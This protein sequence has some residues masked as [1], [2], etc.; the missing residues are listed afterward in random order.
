MLDPRIYQTALIP[1]A[2]AVIVL[3]FSLYDQQ[4]PVGT[5]LAPD[6]FSGDNAY[7]TMNALA[8]AHPRRRPGSADDN[9]IAGL[10]AGRLRTYGFSV[11]TSA[12]RAQT[13]DG[14]R[15]LKN[16]IGVRAGP[17][18]GTIVVVAHRDALGSPA[19][20]QASGTAVLLELAQV[21]SGETQHRTI[22]LA[23]TSGSAGAAGAAQL[24]RSLPGP[25]DAVI[26]L[27]DL[28]ASGAREPIV[29]PWSNGEDLAP[30]R[31]RQTVAAAV[32]AQAGLPAGRTTLT[33]ELAHVALPMATSEQAPFAAHKE[34]ALLVSLSGERQPPAHEP[35]TLA[36]ITSMGRAVLQ[37]VTA[38]DSGPAVPA[39]SA[40]L[41]FAGK[42]IPAWA[43]RVLVLTL[44]LPVLGTAIDGLARARRRG[45][46]PLRSM[47]WVLAAA[48]PFGLAGVAIAAGRATGLI[49]A[50]PPGPVGPGAVPLRGGGIAVLA[51]C[52]FLILTGVV[53]V[54]ALG[55]RLP[56]PRGARGDEGPKASGVPPALLLALCGCSLAIWVTNPFAAAL[57][58]PALHLWLWIL[59][60]D[61]RLRGA[62]VFTLLVA[63]LAPVVLGAV[64]FALT[65]GLGPVKLAWNGVLLIAGGDVHAVSVAEWS[66]V[67][68][69]GVCVALIIGHPAR[70]PRAQQ[71]PVTIRGPVTYAGPGSLGGTESAIRR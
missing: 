35:T 53:V 44:I 69:C 26:A 31:L 8:S 61:L 47:L 38:L 5:A 23:S 28:A 56:A 63:G 25:V 22:V 57:L 40:Y 29:V 62:V 64:Y 15:T 50:A 11:S 30:P 18:N 13:A 20:A 10:V 33:S 14:P 27:G 2:L 70:Q 49:H 71:A 43:V 52:A 9:A 7:T 51:I 37:S 36:R 6:A 32:A 41:L 1:V 17:E 39:P 24:A 58:V 12:F 65:Q 67:L 55:R 59:T 46:R 48:L 16:V 21:L 34:P 60:P 3:A 19:A 68:G 4:G 42:V 45:R 66:I 54:R